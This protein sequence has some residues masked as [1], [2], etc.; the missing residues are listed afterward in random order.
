MEPYNVEIFRPDFEYRSSAQ[1]DV[2]EH[3]FDYMDITKAKVEIPGGNI[4][5]DKGDWIHL[6]RKNFAADG[7]ISDVKVKKDSVVVEY[8]P[9]Q[10]IF[11]VNTYVDI[12]DLEQNSLEDWLAK[13]ISR[14]YISNPDQLQN[15][16]G[17]EI[18][19]V[20]EHKGA[21]LEGYDTG[22]NN[23][24]DIMLSAFTAYG[25]VCDFELSVWNKKLE[26][27]IGS[28]DM[29]V[30]TI[31]AD[32]GNVLAKNITLKED[33]SNTNKL[34]I[35]NE[36]DYTQKVIYYLTSADEVT[37]EDIDRITPVVCKEITAKTT[38]SAT[39]EEVAQKKAEKTLT[40]SEYDN[41]IEITLMEDDLLVKPTQLQIGQK[42]EV[43]SAGVSYK[44]IMTGIQ[45]DEGKVTLIFGA[46]RLEL[47]KIL[48]RRF[49][50][51][52]N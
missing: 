33:D 47:T 30:I 46:I 38:S 6:S 21:A 1:G 39:F 3:E 28:K 52:G 23:L 42:T 12:S 16:S 9:F 49:R 43:I 2:I 35:Y 40:P 37:T 8:K 18:S 36:E 44:T 50:E 20:S 24:Y 25:V 32:L 22:L 27:I 17:L 13:I 48:K 29:A 4:V 11:D 41:L 7:I 51:Y 19:V 14:L 45:Y 34:V 26:L 10:K 5:A 31:E 15:I